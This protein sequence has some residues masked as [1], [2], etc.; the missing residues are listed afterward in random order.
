MSSLGIFF[1]DRKVKET[2]DLP[3]YKLQAATLL[4]KLYKQEN[5]IDSAFKYQQVMIDTREQVFSNEK[6]PANES[7]S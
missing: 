6:C 7:S 5:K 4:T 1:Y 3:V 2:L